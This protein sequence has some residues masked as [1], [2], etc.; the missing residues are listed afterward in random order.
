M[1]KKYGDVLPG[2]A[3]LYEEQKGYRD[4][5]M[6]VGQMNFGCQM[7]RAA[8]TL[9]RWTEE[10]AKP[11]LERKPGYQ[12][13]DVPRLKQSS[14]DHPDELRSAGRPA[15]CSSI[16]SCARSISPTISGSKP[17]TRCSRERQ[18]PEAEK[19]IDAFLDGLYAGTKL[20]SPEERLRMFDLSREDLLE[21]GGF[22][23]R[24]RRAARQGS[25]GARGEG[26]G[27]AGR[28]PAPEPAPHGGVHAVEGGQSLSRR[29][30]HDAPHVRNGERATA[31]GTPYRTDT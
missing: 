15:G 23:R 29:E 13:R 1:K 24:F 5:N 20:G 19:K 25:E 21:A 16:F 30:R 9:D 12:D 6:I 10:K 3:A 28:P 14:P 4:K 8:G 26:Q 7:L 31:R 11:D 2:I 22:L 27:H 17:S 18:G